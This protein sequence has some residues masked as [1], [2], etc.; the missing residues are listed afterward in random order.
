MA[1]KIPRA[2]LNPV[3]RRRGE[4]KTTDKK[5]PQ[6]SEIFGV[7]TSPAQENEKAY[8]TIGVSMSRAHLGMLDAESQFLGLRRGQLLE[9][10]L[11]KELGIQN[12]E[13][14][15]FAPAAYK[16]KHD[17]LAEKVQFLWYIRKEVQKLLEEYLFQRGI[18]PSA[19]AVMALNKWV[20]SS[21]SGTE[22]KGG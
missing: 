8:A 9:L 3:T 20:E 11:L 16:L 15:R 12:L 2:K 5:K 21:T 6:E 18:K 1:T 4:A 22:G 17:E 13:R 7:L 14:S 19:W 10:L